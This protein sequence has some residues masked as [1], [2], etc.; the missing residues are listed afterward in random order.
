[1]SYNVQG[2][3]ISKV[4]ERVRNLKSANELSYDEIDKYGDLLG[5]EMSEKG[6]TDTQLRKIYNII[7][8]HRRKFDKDRLRLIKPLLAYT[9]AKNQSAQDLCNLL[10]ELV[11][12]VNNEIDFEKF[13]KLMEAI[14]AYY[15]YYEETKPQSNKQSRYDR[16]E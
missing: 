15:K 4:K 12:K 9:A 16:M 10:R 2:M 3:N 14:V 8:L 6:L 1:M 5:R 13:Y 7:L 11:D